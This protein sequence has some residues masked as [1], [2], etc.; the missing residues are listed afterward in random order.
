MIQNT[1]WHSL[2]RQF[3]PLTSST[4]IIGE[5]F[6]LYRTSS[7]KLPKLPRF[8]SES[9]LVDASFVDTHLKNN[10][11]EDLNHNASH[12]FLYFNSFLRKTRTATWKQTS[13]LL[14]PRD[15]IATFDGS[16][17]VHDETCRWSSSVDRREP[18]A[19]SHLDEPQISFARAGAPLFGH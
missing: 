14:L 12:P 4:K 9:L 11:M 15:R 13:R 10:P 8:R 2:G 1:T 3:P 19:Q 18:R 16:H 5:K 6:I 7:V 17:V